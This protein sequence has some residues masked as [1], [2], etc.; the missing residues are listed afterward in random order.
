MKFATA[1]KPTPLSSPKLYYIFGWSYSL[2][3]IIVV[4]AQL[5]YFDKLVDMAVEHSMFGGRLGVLFLTAMVTIG[6]FSLPYLLRLTMS[7]ALRI[8]S[9][10]CAYAL[11]ILWAIL[12]WKLLKMDVADMGLL[13]T[14]S[15]GTGIGGMLITTLGLFLA[16]PAIY[17]TGD[18]RSKH[19][20]KHR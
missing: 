8:V 20:R 10:A 13:G 2:L 9:W 11:P 3:V 6:V 12:V 18:P 7:P 15:L 5:F 4:T 16:F 1:T 17:F 19:L 14:I